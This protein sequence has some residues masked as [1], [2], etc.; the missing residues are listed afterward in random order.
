M[1]PS[2]KFSIVGLT[3]VF[4]VVFLMSILK[5]KMAFVSRAPVTHIKEPVVIRYKPKPFYTD[6]RAGKTKVV[7]KKK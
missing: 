6:S 1:A 5:N 7:L 4:A 3:G 2:L